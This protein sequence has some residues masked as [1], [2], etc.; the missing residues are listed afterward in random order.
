MSKVADV[1]LA[2]KYGAKGISQKVAIR[3]VFFKISDALNRNLIRKI[4]RWIEYVQ[5]WIKIHHLVN[6]EKFNIIHVQWLL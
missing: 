5:A 6:K 1:T 3:N 4:I 2:T